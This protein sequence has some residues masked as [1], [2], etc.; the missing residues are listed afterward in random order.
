[1]YARRARL[2]AYYFDTGLEVAPY[3]LCVDGTGAEPSAY[4]T[5]EIG[6]ITG[7]GLR[8]PRWGRAPDV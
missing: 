3:L 2:R 7:L 6:L 4:G 8:P 1:M 5:S